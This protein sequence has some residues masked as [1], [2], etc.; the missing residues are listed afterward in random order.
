MYNLNPFEKNVKGSDIKFAASMETV[1]C[2]S[3]L[4]VSWGKGG[5]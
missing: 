2:Y 3:A 5:S 4:N 1:T